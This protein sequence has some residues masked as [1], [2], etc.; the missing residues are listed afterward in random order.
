[1]VG[2]FG[3]HLPPP[4]PRTN[5]RPN[6]KWNE[7]PNT[8]GTSP[9]RNVQLVDSAAANQHKLSVKAYEVALE[10]IEATCGELAEMAL[11]SI[12]EPDDT[13]AGKI[14]GD[15][16]SD[17]LNEQ[18]KKTKRI[19]K[20]QLQLSTKELPSKLPSKKG[21]CATG[22]VS[23]GAEW[24]VNQMTEN[25]NP[26]QSNRATLGE[27]LFTTICQNKTHCTSHRYDAQIDIV[28]NLN[29]ATPPTDADNTG[30]PLQ[31]PQSETFHRRGL[32]MELYPV[33]SSASSIYS[34]SYIN[35]NMLLTMALIMMVCF[36]LFEIRQR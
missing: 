19:S 11:K 12:N 9:N 28:F 16:L 17:I 30:L 2:K 3:V 14:V 20:R 24:T 1:M 8:I 10:V 25:N 15:S 29:I 34:P 21:S 22:V 18:L 26:N 6:G 32:P 7:R 36:Y 33:S 27:K 5:G 23:A 13:L 35:N 4:P 31:P